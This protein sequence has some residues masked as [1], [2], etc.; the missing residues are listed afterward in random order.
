ME[1]NVLKIRATAPVAHACHELQHT[2]QETIQ[3][4]DGWQVL[5]ALSHWI[6]THLTQHMAVLEDHPTPGLGVLDCGVEKVLSSLSGL[7]RRVAQQ[8]LDCNPMLAALSFLCG[9]NHK[10]LPGQRQWLLFAHPVMRLCD[11][12][13]SGNMLALVVDITFP[14]SS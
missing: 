3:R 1:I 5:I 8:R 12:T 14:T 4:K 11:I 9:T 10:S 13:A 6:K 2:L 7:N